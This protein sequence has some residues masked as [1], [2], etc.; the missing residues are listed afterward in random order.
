MNEATVDSIRV[1]VYEVPTDQPEADGTLAWDKTTVV[2]V[3]V[4]AAGLTGLG[5]T[6]AAGACKPLIDDTLAAV[7]LGRSAYDVPGAWEAMVRAIRNLGRPGLVSCA[8]SAVDAALWDLKAKL[9]DLP[10]CRLLGTVH[11]DVPIYGSG[12]FTTYDDDATRRQI[13]RWVG[14][15]GIPRVKIKIGQSW[16]HATGRDLA[17]VALT[18][19]LAGAETA[20]YVDANGGYSRKQAIRVAAAMQDHAVTW[21]EEPVSSDDLSGLGEIRAQTSI[22]IAAGEYGYSLV[23]FDRMIR[24]GA[25]DCL[26]VDVTR[27]GGIT[28]WVRVAALAAAAGLEVSG[29]CAPNLHAHV[30]ASV[31]NLR[32]L[33]YFHDHVRIE[34]LFFD[35]ALDPTGGSLHPDQGRPGLGLVLRSAD[36]EHYRVG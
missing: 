33:E 29:H 10:L 27:C 11:P 8:I 21:F 36:A 32:H 16:G 18:R 2:I 19:Q 13:E 22:D 34:D 14:E 23:Y 31:P 26:Q 28:E 5:Y 15:W 12:G 9:V 3:E 30:A 35:G 17:R 25:V 20:V 7:V 1:G 6:Y 4:D 24:A